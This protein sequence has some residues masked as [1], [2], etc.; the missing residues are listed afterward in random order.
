MAETVADLQWPETPLVNH[1]TRWVQWYLDDVTG[2]LAED[3]EMW[4]HVTPH[5]LRRTWATLLSADIDDPILVMDFGGWEKIET[6]LKHYCGSYSPTVQRRELSKV[7]WLDVGG[8]SVGERGPELSM[9]ISH[10]R[11]H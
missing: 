11:R 6:F 9:L 3:D 8:R 4:A 5:D 10:L 7:D 1:S 2:E